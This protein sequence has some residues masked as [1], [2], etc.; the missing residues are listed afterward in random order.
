MFN[1]NEGTVDKYMIKNSEY[2]FKIYNQRD[3]SLFT[4]GRGDVKLKKEERKERCSC[5]QSSFDYKGRESV[6]LGRPYFTAKRI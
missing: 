1:I 4:I 2:A 5:D 6:L 3:E